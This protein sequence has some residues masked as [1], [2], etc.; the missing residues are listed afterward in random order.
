M[1][2]DP[3]NEEEGTGMTVAY[4]KMKNLF[5]RQSYLDAWEDYKRRL[6]KRSFIKWDNVILTASN[7]E[8]AKGYR[9]QIE[10]RLEKSFCRRIRTMP[11]FRIRTGNGSE[12]EARRFRC[13]G[14]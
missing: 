4:K 7:E 3:M 6:N 11:F 1:M 5:L 10:E 8:Q 13:C 9:S 14:I 12:A 2:P